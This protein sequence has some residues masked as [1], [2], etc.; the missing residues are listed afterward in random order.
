M[1]AAETQLR[2]GTTDTVSSLTPPRKVSF[3]IR[4]RW[5]SYPCRWA[6]RPR[7]SPTASLA[8]LGSAICV[9]MDAAHLGENRAKSGKSEEVEKTPTPI[10]NLV[11]ERETTYVQD[12]K[13]P[14]LPGEQ[15]AVFLTTATLEAKIRSRTRRPRIT[16]SAN[17]K[18]TGRPK[19]QMKLRRTS[20]RKTG[21]LMRAS[22]DIQ[23][24]LDVTIAK[25]DG[26]NQVQYFVDVT[27]H[28]ETV[29]GAARPTC[30]TLNSAVIP[31][32]VC[33]SLCLPTALFFAFLVKISSASRF[34]SVNLS[35]HGGTCLGFYLPLAAVTLGSTI[36]SGKMRHRTFDGVSPCRERSRSACDFCGKIFPNLRFWN[37]RR[38][39]IFPN[40]LKRVGMPSA[41]PFIWRRRTIS[42]R[43]PQKRD[44]QA[45][46]NCGLETTAL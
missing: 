46:P 5:W 33:V 20:L 32:R 23:Q 22:E 39:P 43:W 8:V 40:K 27:S 10:A 9:W 37:I 11:W 31:G 30:R 4:R 2:A 3:A 17:S 34:A 16:S 44:A 45:C 28:F 7:T 12:D 41:S 21:L 24:S 38:T 42:W 14:I 6:G 25:A 13:C 35:H 19:V 15:C 29:S 1:M 18:P 26:T 36:I